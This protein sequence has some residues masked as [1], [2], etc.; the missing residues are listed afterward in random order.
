MPSGFH[1]VANRTKRVSPAKADRTHR[2]PDIAGDGLCEYQDQLLGNL[3]QST[4]ECLGAVTSI[5]TFSKGA[6]V[7]AEGQP[8][9]GVLVLRAGRITLSTPCSDHKALILRIAGPGE[10]LDLAATI[11]GKAHELTAEAVEAV[12]VNFISA[13]D[14]LRCMHEK[15]DLALRTA[16]LLSESWRLA[17]AEM[18]MTR[19]SLSARDRLARFL[20]DLCAGHIEDKNEM[21]ITLALTHAEIAQTIGTSR[22]TVTRLFGDFKQKQFLQVKGSTLTI[23][24]KTGLE[25]VVGS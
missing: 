4:V 11:T 6:I 25:R 14:F 2:R 16:Q 7:F 18:R 15:S 10:I 19:A 17:I 8:S 9:R 3:S 20:L 21:K 1:I 12:E 5:E 24:N 13:K 23:K 22:E